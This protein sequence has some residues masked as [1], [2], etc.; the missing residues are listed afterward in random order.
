MPAWDRRNIYSL[1]QRV[2]SGL[3]PK[4]KPTHYDLDP[5]GTVHITDA[6]IITGHDFYI[7]SENEEVRLGNIAS[8]RFDATGL[9]PKL[10]F[11]PQVHVFFHIPDA[12]GSPIVTIDGMTSEVVER[13]S[14]MPYGSVDSDYRPQRWAYYRFSQ[15]FAGKTEDPESGL[16]DFGAR[17]YSPYLGRF[18]SPDPVSTHALNPDGNAYSYAAGNPVGNL[19]R[20]GLAPYT[21]E[22]GVLHLDPDYI[23]G[24]PPPQPPPAPQPQTPAAPQAPNAGVAGVRPLDLDTALNAA[25]D[26]DQPIHLPLTEN[27]YVTANHVRNEMLNGII[28]GLIDSADPLGLADGVA[29]LSGGKADLRG[30]VHQNTGDDPNDES[31]TAGQVAL[32]LPLIWNIRG[33]AEIAAFAAEDAK[34]VSIMRN[35]EAL[36]SSKATQQTIAVAVGRD[37]RIAVATSRGGFLPATEA[38]I[39]SE[40]YIV[41][42]LE[43]THAEGTV[44]SGSGDSF[45]P[46]RGIASNIICAQCATWIQDSLGGIRTGPRSFFFPLSIPRK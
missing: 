35:V 12:M 36:Q 4:G 6:A 16:L 11:D 33:W 45:I 25:V 42:T 18:L 26:N 43:H 44:I 41:A 15:R 37:G 28:N 31:K 46:Y 23:N 13:T 21:D 34:M 19:D 9:W 38:W 17:F 2:I 8:V 27:S 3:T 32:V 7:A 29:A 39:K 40:G 10:Y 14:Y 30:A 1:G 24:T 20:N 22:D 5:L